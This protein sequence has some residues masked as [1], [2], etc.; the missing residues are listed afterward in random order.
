MVRFREP[1][2]SA[3]IPGAGSEG[4]P[5]GCLQGDPVP[6]WTHSLVCGQDRPA[7]AFKEIP[8]TFASRV[9]NMFTFGGCMACERCRVGRLID[10]TALY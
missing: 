8:S 10:K 9:N 7:V 2:L 3:G 5:E 4:L 6:V 1:Y